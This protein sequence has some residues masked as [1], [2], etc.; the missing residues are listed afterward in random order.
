MEVLFLKEAVGAGG[1]LGLAVRTAVVSDNVEAARRVALNDARSAAAV[2]GDAVQVDDR[3]ACL[4]V[5]VTSP[6]LECHAGCAESGVL[7]RRWSRGGGDVPGWVQQRAR[8][9]GGQ[10]CAC[11]EHAADQ[12]SADHKTG[13]PHVVLMIRDTSAASTSARELA[14]RR[15]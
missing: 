13:T 5:R 15:S 14:S 7:A 9:D 8:A 3:P 11:R 6:P 12:H 1:A 10:A 2:V 4:R